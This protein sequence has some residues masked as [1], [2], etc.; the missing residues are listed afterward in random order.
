M[1]TLEQHLK[2]LS[3][4]LNKN[5]R[6]IKKATFKTAEPT[7]KELSNYRKYAEIVTKIA[8]QINWTALEKKMYMRIAERE[9]K[10][11]CKN[12]GLRRL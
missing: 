12:N 4:L 8:Q 3:K 5:E 11:Y 7:A 6:V 10:Q 1:R 9:Y 2:E